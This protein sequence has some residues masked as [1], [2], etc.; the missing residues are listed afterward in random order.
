MKDG[1]MPQ[2]KTDRRTLYTRMVIQDA[3]LTLLHKKEFDRITVTDICKLAEI[4]RSTFYLHYTDALAVFDDLLDGLLAQMLQMLTASVP[5]STS[6]DQLFLL[7]G[8]VV[9]RQILQDAKLSFL[10]KKGIDS[11]RFAEKY[12]ETFAKFSLPFFQKHTALPQ[13][14]LLLVLNGLFYSYMMLDGYCL[15]NHSVKELEHCNALFN[16]YIFGPCQKKILSGVLPERSDE[17]SR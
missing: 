6:I 12:A 1:P 7:S 11:P 13:G 10:L 9:Y 4:N 2:R 14:D 15:K 3:Y 8:D 17:N 16:Y 5:E